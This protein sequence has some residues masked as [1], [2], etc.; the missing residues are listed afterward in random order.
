VHLCVPGDRKLDLTA[1]PHT[2]EKGKSNTAMQSPMG[3]EESG[4]Q[5]VP[6]PKR[7]D[8]WAYMYYYVHISCLLHQSI[9]LLHIIPEYK[10]GRVC[11]IVIIA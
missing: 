6:N 9:F 11:V 2:L 3:N 1:K 5:P 7:F 4:R 8:L 10:A